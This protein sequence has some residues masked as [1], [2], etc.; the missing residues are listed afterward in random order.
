V[1]PA[2]PAARPAAPATPAK[3][4]GTTAKK[5]G[6]T[7]KKSAGGSTAAAGKPKVGSLKSPYTWLIIG[8][9][10]L[11]GGAI[12]LLR[13]KSS[14]TAT[15][16]AA[17][18]GTTDSGTSSDAPLGA[19]YY[20]DGGVGGYGGD[21][22]T[23]LGS[24][25]GDQQSTT[26]PT[27]QIAVP[28]VQAATAAEATTIIKAAGLHPVNPSGTPASNIVSSTSPAAGTMVASGSDVDINSAPKGS[29]GSS[30]SGSGSGTSGSSSSGSSG[31]ASSGSSSAST[32]GETAG[33]WTD[34][35]QKWSPVQ[36]AINLGIPE[37]NLKGSNAAGI[38]A[39][40][41]PVSTIPSG[42]KFTFLK[43]A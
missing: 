15:T 39:L 35:G 42:A 11:V 14:S 8:G 17:G 10:A 2:K 30:S 9:I 20:D 1:P 43:P 29:S 18:T 41:A 24:T 23:D 12:I 34:T 13:K 40:K 27:G 5:T 32:A 4:T 28:N 19:G 6:T 37:S 33:S 38:A 36:L 21:S 26:T 25:I 31:S 22:G 7:A 16:A 3:K